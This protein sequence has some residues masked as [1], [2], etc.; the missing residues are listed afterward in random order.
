[1]P[2]AVVISWIACSSAGLTCFLVRPFRRT[3]P[4]PSGTA[5]GPFGP[6]RCCWPSPPPRCGPAGSGSRRRPGS[7]WSPRCRETCVA[8]DAAQRRGQGVLRHH[9]PGH[10]LSR[11]VIECREHQNNSDV[12]YQPF[13]ELVPEE[14]DVHA[15]HDGYQREHVKHDGCLSS[16]HFFLLCATEWA[17]SGAGFS[18]TL[19]LTVTETPV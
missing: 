13:P 4:G 19:A 16:Y 5:R 14:Q 12:Y 11:W 1:M 15:D 18:E 3:G 7:G 17:K 2:S 10:D 6:G 9:C 8:A